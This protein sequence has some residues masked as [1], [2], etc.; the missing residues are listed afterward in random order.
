MNNNL[1]ERGKLII[2]NSKYKNIIKLCKNLN[3]KFL[4]NEPLK[5]HTTFKIGGNADLLIIV[6]N[7]NNIEQLLKTIKHENIPF[8][9]IGR[10]SN[11]LV[12]DD[13]Y[14]GIV[15]KFESKESIT[16]NA[17]IITCSSGIPLAKAC[18]FAMKNGLSGL[19]FAW[20]IPGT[21]G[22]A[23]YMNAGAYGNDMSDVIYT[24]THIDEKG[25][26]HTFEKKDMDLSYRHS[27]YSDNSYI[28]TSMQFKLMPLEKSK[29][30]AKMYENILKRKTKQPLQYASAGS[31][32]K[33]PNIEGYYASALIQQAN[34]KGVS[35]GQAQVSE[36]H[37]GFII[38]KGNATA[39]DICKLIKIV[40]DKVYQNSS[41]KLECEIK[42]L[43]NLKI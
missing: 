7:T 40:K 12:S 2:L 35:C 23:L 37:S 21:C 34:L 36:K 5:N 14:R 28:I 43:G 38:N 41:I 8:Y 10:G 42:T 16:K 18:V 17:D 27:T 3:F 13:G 20:G 4:E 19:E 15:L 26:Y 39:K 11:M 30:K 29:I 32:F 9:V 31:T 24:A 22:G 1:L 6:H 25:N 33:R